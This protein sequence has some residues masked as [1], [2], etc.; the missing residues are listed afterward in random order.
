MEENNSANDSAKKDWIQ[1][2]VLTEDCDSGD[3]YSWVFA[4][5]EDAYSKMREIL[6][7]QI[8]HAAENED[9][10]PAYHCKVFIDNW[11]ASLCYL[12]EDNEIVENSKF[13]WR[14]YEG[15]TTLR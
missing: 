4:S 7:L 3:P 2:W 1:V 13:S 11:S 8:E 10:E 14:I 6:M 15:E 9:D 5:K 12:N